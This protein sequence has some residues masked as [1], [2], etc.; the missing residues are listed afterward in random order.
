ML[1]M[2]VPSDSLGGDHK[3]KEV[4]RGILRA[5]VGV[6]FSDPRTP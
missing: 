2:D 5:P 4:D 3:F 6:E 1:E